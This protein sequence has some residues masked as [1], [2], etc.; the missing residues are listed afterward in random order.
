MKR[1]ILLTFVV[2]TVIGCERYDE[3]VLPI[4]GLYQG[5]VVGVTRP[6]KFSISAKYGDNLEIDAPMDGDVWDVVTLDIDNKDD[7]VMR[8]RIPF[9]TLEDGVSIKGDGFFQNG[10]IQLNYSITVDGRKANF[11]LIGEQW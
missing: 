8:V 10:T 4:V 9:Q 11:R 5:Q 6:F 3:R 2:L 7:E 1:L